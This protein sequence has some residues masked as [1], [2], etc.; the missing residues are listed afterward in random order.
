LHISAALII[1]G[2]IIRVASYRHLGRF[3]TLQL[4]I[5]D[6][7]KLVK[8]GPYRVVRHPAYTGGLLALLGDLCYQLGPASI[9]AQ[10]GLWQSIPA[11]IFGITKIC[12][13]AYINVVA[14]ML[15]VNEEDRVLREQFRGEWEAWARQ[16][17]YKLVPFVY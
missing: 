6:G 2:T 14:L 17:Q 4:A 3:F 15:R 13:A 5:R 9:W 12:L 10:L 8:D 1:A 7:H 11:C 16:T